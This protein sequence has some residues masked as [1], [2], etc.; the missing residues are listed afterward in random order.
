M[1]FR[2]AN[3]DDLD[4]ILEALKEVID[5]KTPF[6]NWDKNYPNR[7]VFK[8]DIEKQH[9]YI[10]KDEKI[11]AVIGLNEEKDINYEK[12][13]WDNKEKI[14]FVHRLFTPYSRRSEGFGKEA[15]KH[16]VALAKEK[17]MNGIHLD[18]FHKNKVAHK[19]YEGLG[20]E[21][22]GEIPLEGKTGK[23]YCYELS[24]K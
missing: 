12:V 3:L 14:L 2:L 1:Q 13:Q 16:A 15:I 21:F 7:E 22:R 18:T 19:F 9:L 11:A 24:I 4:E 17:N 10:L 23:F 6:M 8:K 20:F 5:N